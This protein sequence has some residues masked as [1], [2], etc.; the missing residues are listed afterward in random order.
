MFIT[1]E[2]LE[3]ALHVAT[4]YSVNEKELIEVSYLRYCH[5][6]TDSRHEAEG[7]SDTSTGASS[8]ES[9]VCSL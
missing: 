9:L 5:F 4:G 3:L 6:I 7:V 2:S 8:V 1:P